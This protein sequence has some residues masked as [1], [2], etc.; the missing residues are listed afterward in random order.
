M[1]RRGFISRLG[2]VAMAV[3][4]AVYAPGCLKDESPE[5]KWANWTIKYTNSPKADMLH[6]LNTAMAHTNNGL[7]SIDRLVHAYEQAT[8]VNIGEVLT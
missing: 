8:G 1:N 7:V 2:G 4:A 5:K 3:A 6:V